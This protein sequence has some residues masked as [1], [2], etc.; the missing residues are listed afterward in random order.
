MH[1]LLINVEG[2]FV[3]IGRQHGNMKLVVMRPL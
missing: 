1:Y 2:H 3:L